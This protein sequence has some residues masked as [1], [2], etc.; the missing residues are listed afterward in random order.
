MKR[1]KIFHLLL[2]FCF[3]SIRNIIAQ[4]MY[5]DTQF[6]YVKQQLSSKNATIIKGYQQ[7]KEEADKAL[8]SSSHAL[9]DFNVPGRYIDSLA[10]V[11]NSK[12][13]QTDAFNAYACALIY[14]LKGEK[15]YGFKAI[16]LLNS[17]ANKNKRFSE[18]DGSLVMA[19]SGTGLMNAALLM[20][21]EKIWKD[22]DKDTFK[23][24]TKDVYKR[25]ADSIRYRKNNWADWGRYASIL[26]ASFLSDK[27]EIIL[28]CNLIKSDISKKIANDGSMPEEIIRGENGLWY[29]YFSLAP[30]TASAW[31]IYNETGEN[32]FEMNFDGI[33]I[34]KALD[35]LLYYSI[36]YDK[37]PHCDKINRPTEGG[38]P[39]NL[40]EAMGKIY[41]D[42][43]YTNFTRKKQPIIYNHHHYAWSFPTLMPPIINSNNVFPDIK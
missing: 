3:M 7:L 11:K 14:R 26:S 36:H 16:E 28:N 2:L 34:K 18:F 42:N 13:L 4:G 22:N 30:I 35:Y 39:Y 12:S 27:N 1:Y 8:K 5:S 40:F 6:L 20:K 9:E 24:W 33:N 10:H 32:L 25:A 31:V 29:T 15:R 23:K 21:N 17:W 19:Y 38:W 43:N 41:N 37:W